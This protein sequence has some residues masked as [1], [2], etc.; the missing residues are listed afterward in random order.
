MGQN[1]NQIPGSVIVAIFRS[2]LIDLLKSR[3]IECI[4]IPILIKIVQCTGGVGIETARCVSGPAIDKAWEICFIEEVVSVRVV[5]P[6]SQRIQ[7]CDDFV[8][9]TLVEIIPRLL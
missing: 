4:D 3:K 9:L 2:R 8:L 5:L 7:E 1:L 6:A